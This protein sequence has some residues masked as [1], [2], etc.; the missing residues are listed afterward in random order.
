[1]LVALVTFA[2]C[3]VARPTPV[4]G[5]PGPTGFATFHEEGLVFDYPASWRDYRY[6][7]ISTMSSV[8]AYLATVDVPEP[9]STAPVSGGT[10]ISCADRFRLEPDTLVVKVANNGWPGFDILGHRPADA[11]PLVVG[12]LPAYVE[13]APATATELGADLSLVW[14][15]S[16]PGFVD[17][18]YTISADIRG[19]DT[20][21]LK[22]QVEAL[23]GS[24]H[25][26]PP[27]VPLPTGSAATDAA[28]AKAFAT[29]ASD[30]P[31]W[32]CFPTRPGT[33]QMVVQSLVMGP[34]LVKPQL[35]TCTT[36]IE[37]TA[38][39]LWRLTLTLRLPETDPAAGSGQ[40]ITL[41]V[42]P[43]GS[44]GSTSA[45]QLGP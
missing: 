19:P 14:T 39:E 36:V 7:V 43:D 4:P 5:T 15:L 27:V 9:C 32:R 33:A 44:P 41:W 1:L 20:E 23:V 25:Y 45:S 31:T 3:T 13:T 2:A 18:F 16:M 26:D 8:I 40:V 11:T 10:Q 17:N 22:G 28:M 6:S 34:D 37:P 30:S 35:A 42:G 29:L 12:G 24:L 38:L 21:R